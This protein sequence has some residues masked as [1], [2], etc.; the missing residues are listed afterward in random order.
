MLKSLLLGL[1]ISM[2]IQSCSVSGKNKQNRIGEEISSSIIDNKSVILTSSEH[3]KWLL[4]NY[5][6]E[7][8]IP[9]KDD[10]L[11]VE[12]AIDQAIRNDE[13]KFLDEPVKKHV[14]GYYKQFIPYINSEGDRIIL[15]N[16]FC[17]LFE[18]PPSIEEDD[19]EWKTVDWQNEYI[20]VDDG[21]WFFWHVTI[22]VD[23]QEYEDFVVNDIG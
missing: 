8:W 4:K 13:F 20:V 6:Y 15:L 14:I 18:V 9:G 7:A 10:I 1:T 2:S 19:Q 21:G 22:N 3:N 16:A 11:I 12:N 17:E 5:S 23:K